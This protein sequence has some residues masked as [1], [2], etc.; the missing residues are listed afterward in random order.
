M[1]LRIERILV[2][3]LDNAG[4][5]NYLSA[6]LMLPRNAREIYAHAYQSYLWNKMA[7]ARVLLS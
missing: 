6:F 4:G 3:A 1:K 2:Q 5:N 7:S